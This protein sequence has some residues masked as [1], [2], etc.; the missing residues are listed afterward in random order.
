VATTIVDAAEAMVKL[1]RVVAAV[2][3]R[4]NAGIEV[5]QGSCD[6]GESR[7]Q[8]RHPL[9]VIKVTKPATVRR[10]RRHLGKAHAI[11]LQRFDELLGIAKEEKEQERER[12]G[13]NP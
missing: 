11:Y 7:S 4:E 6:A 13:A 10:I 12:G 3:G 8:R 9:Q 5:Y 2:K 1:E